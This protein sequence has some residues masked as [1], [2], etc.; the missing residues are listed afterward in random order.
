VERAAYENPYSGP[1]D[2][3]TLRDPRTGAHDFRD[4]VLRGLKRR[5]LE[6]PAVADMARALE[7]AGR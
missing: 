2:L 1:G 4:A 3:M 6:S 7:S 5:G